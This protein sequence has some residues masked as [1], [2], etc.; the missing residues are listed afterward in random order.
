[1]IGNVPELQEATQSEVMVGELGTVAP[2][3]LAAALFAIYVAMQWISNLFAK[4]TTANEIV[5]STNLKDNLLLSKGL[6]IEVVPLSH[7]FIPLP[8]YFIPPPHFFISL[9]QTLLKHFDLKSFFW[10]VRDEATPP[11]LCDDVAAFW[12]LTF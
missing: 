7:C 3:L 11:E 9:P 2:E 1:M 8:L 12:A 4:C 5:K 10:A 6:S